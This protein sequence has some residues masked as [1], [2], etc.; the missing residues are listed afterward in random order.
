MKQHRKET[1]YRFTAKPWLHPGAGGWV[2]V[3]LPG[4]L[5]KQIRSFLKA[6]EEG[7][8]RLKATAI[9]GNSEWQ[10]SIWFDTKLNA[11]LLPLKAEIRKK[12]G[13]VVGKEIEVLIRPCF[14][15]ISLIR[16]HGS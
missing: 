7:W 11:Y 4:K 3:A 14:R 5:S 2:F 10:T 1:A 15:V 12:E 8:G 13:V 9:V 6:E 16:S